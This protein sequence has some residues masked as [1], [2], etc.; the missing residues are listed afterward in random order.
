MC[1][2][3]NRD[4]AHHHLKILMNKKNIPAVFVTEIDPS[5]GKALLE[6]LQAQEFEISKP[7][8]TLFSGKKNGI[9]CT[10]YASGKLVIQGKDKEEFI[11]FYIEPEI[12]KNFSYTYKKAAE[13]DPTGRIGIDES[14][15]GDFFGPLCVAGVYAEGSAIAQL[16]K[17]GV[18]DSKAMNDAAILKI[19]KEIRK[20]TQYHILKINPPKYNELYEK[21]K[22]LNRLLA[23]AHATTI[24][25]LVEKTDCRNVIVD[26]FANEEVVKTAL[27]RKSL[28]VNL[29]QRHRAEED[30]VVAAASILAREAFLLGLKQLGE[31][32]G[33]LLPKGASKQTIDAGKRLVVMHGEDAL[34]KVGKLHFKTLDSIQF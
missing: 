14:G 5:Q 25:S 33:L 8:Y 13:H 19:A 17:I 21:F 15:K 26:Q 12:L 24:E 7:P 2:V 3:Y 1:L 34:G 9:S 4:H 27:K 20:S 32:F 31:Q 28:E 18:K 22:N 29:T 6:L 23:W 11:E 10:L 16:A 30:L